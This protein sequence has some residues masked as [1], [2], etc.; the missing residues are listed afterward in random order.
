MRPYFLITFFALSMSTHAQVDNVRQILNSKWPSCD[1][2]REVFENFR[3]RQIEDLSRNYGP[4]YYEVY[5]TFQNGQQATLYL[6]M[7]YSCDY[8]SFGG[9]GCSTKYQCQIELH[10]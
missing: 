6:T 10:Q 1:K 3:T 2:A 9:G 8:G 5:G 4:S 7:A